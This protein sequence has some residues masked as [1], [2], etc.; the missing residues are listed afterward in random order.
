MMRGYTK[1]P[2]FA[3]AGWR[4]RNPGGPVGGQYHGYLANG[5]ND[6]SLP[7]V[8]TGS[9]PVASA[10]PGACGVSG[11]GLSGIVLREGQTLSDHVYRAPGEVRPRANASGDLNTFRSLQ[12]MASAGYA[13][14]PGN[15]HDIGRYGMG[16]MPDG[17]VRTIP[18]VVAAPTIVPTPGFPVVGASTGVPRL[19]LPAYP[20]QITMRPI[21][22]VCP[23]WGC[24]P[25]YGATASVP[26]PPPPNVPVSS[27]SI[28]VWSAPPISPTP[29]PV[30]GAKPTDFLP[31]QGQPLPGTTPTATAPAG[32]GIWDW[33]QASTIW[34]GVPNGILAAG[35][36]F[37]LY[38][39][40]GK[41][42]R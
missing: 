13:E 24:G 1:A 25:Y 37:A 11:V 17:F 2:D 32:S 41:G 10:D 28:P 14:A 12:Q 21:D 4:L 19:P 34:A 35:A 40:S 33:L 9:P 30:V 29:A 16:L 38:A 22:Y 42:K 23:A 8:A 3:W 15:Y 7:L 31:S 20:D 39:L 6:E 5:A 36:A 26:Q 18:N 27:P